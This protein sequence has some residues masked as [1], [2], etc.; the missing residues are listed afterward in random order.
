MYNNF[1]N[2]H[3]TWYLEVFRAAA[4][5][6]YRVPASR[7]PPRGDNGQRSCTVIRQSS[8]I[9][10]LKNHLYAVMVGTRKKST[11][12]GVGTPV[13]VAGQGKKAGPQASSS[14]NRSSTSVGDLIS[15]S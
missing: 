4:H 6:L 8:W 5:K 1:F 9:T 13:S 10:I 15:K 2:V 7:A 11:M 14:S 12:Q 3:K